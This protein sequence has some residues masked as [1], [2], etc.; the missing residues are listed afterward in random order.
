[1]QRSLMAVA[2][3]FTIAFGM[4]H[5]DYI[6]IKIN[7]GASPEA[8]L[9]VP[10][11]PE[12]GPNGLP[13]PNQPKKDP[14]PDKGPAAKPKELN[15][16]ITVIFFEFTKAERVATGLPNGN[17]FN[18]RLPVAQGV[19]ITK[20]HHK[21]GDSFVINDGKYVYMSDPIKRP[22]VL[23]SFEKKSKDLIG[24]QKTP[25][26]LHELAE[27]ALTHGLH[28]QCTETME[29]LTKMEPKGPPEVVKAVQAFEK[30]RK[31]LAADVGRD[32]QAIDWQKHL[33]YK[34]ARSAH[35]SLLY[36]TSGPPEVRSRLDR[37]EKN[38]EAF[39]Y[40]FA[41]KGK[42]LPAPD[43]RLVA[44]LVDKPKEFQQVQVACEEP[45]LV[46]DGF[47]A[48]RENLAV[49]SA[50]RLDP[51]SE[52]LSAKFNQMIEAGWDLK[53]LLNPKAV[54]KPPGR[55]TPQE[56][57]HAHTLALIKKA[58]EEESEI[59]TT[60]HLGSRQLLAAT[61]LLPRGVEIPEWIQF[62]WA[63]FFETPKF[64]PLN[65]MLAHGDS[66]TGAFWTGTGAPSWT[67]LPQF[68]I[69]ENLKRLDDPALAIRQLVS[70]VYFRQAFLGG[71]NLRQLY[72]SRAYA[73]SFVYYLSYRQLD[74]LLRY[75][76]ELAQLPRDLE[77]DGDVHLACF[78]RA[79]NLTDASGGLDQ[80]KLTAM[81]KD[82]YKFISIEPLQM[83]ELLQEA[84]KIIK[85]LQ[86]KPPDP[87]AK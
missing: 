8:M 63:S 65:I 11:P 66:H 54:V 59:A 83:P 21:W 72:K 37:L 10:K 17:Q 87:P 1:M 24:K 40:W 80:A 62:G 56:Q 85:E 78:A 86:I 29:E 13:L 39:Y 38:I 68:K 51:P 3:L 69:W 42:K 64:D 7:M 4:A 27:Y 14:I 20:V 35:Y 53:N 45:P 75:G 28:K 58:L 49:F 61:G 77:L 60:S 76:Q 23:Q 33:N 6:V 36:D 46:A 48:R 70:D 31:D 79:F 81:G 15:K 34:V 26:K 47:Y 41:L 52:P 74:G 22:T 12:L 30:V 50:N 5:A 18:P 9:A 82:W 25:E 16:L 57:A 2:A 84:Q 71:W 67:Y 43:R 73:W 44:L 55:F 32:D 19:V